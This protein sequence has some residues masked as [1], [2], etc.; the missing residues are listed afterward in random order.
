MSNLILLGAG[1]SY[2]AG[3]PL[4]VPM[5]GKMPA[6]F[7]RHGMPKMA[8]RHYDYIVR[9]LKK[10]YGWQP[11]VEQVYQAVHGLMMRRHDPDGIFARTWDKRVSRF[12]PARRYVAGDKGYVNS[13]YYALGQVMRHALFDL[14]YIEDAEK[15]A[16]YVPMVQA[17]ARS[18][19]P[20][21]SLNYDNAVELAAKQLG[22]GVDLG[23]SEWT[24]TRRLKWDDTK[25]HLLKLHGSVLWQY[26]PD[27]NYGPQTFANFA[28]TDPD[29]Q[30]MR[31]WETMPYV[32]FGAGN[33]LS[34]EAFML[35]LMADFEAR[36]KGAEVLHAIGYSFADP[37]VNDLIAR[38]MQDEKILYVY[39]VRSKEQVHEAL[40]TT[41]GGLSII[42]NGPRLWI[43]EG[44]GAVEAFQRNIPR[45]L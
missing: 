39:D 37:H 23:L 27:P 35:N 34:A 8:I 40:K 13:N 29:V 9:T 45:D 2:N 10:S 18:R 30:Y 5:T 17:A 20:I 42:G 6:V 7:K 21:V 33:K 24:R 22:I 28:D 25:L 16:Y 26:N 19:T 4:A 36:L 14:T 3:V 11:N 38:W 12:D 1:A 32:V 41:A 31:R 43:E 15:T 44:V